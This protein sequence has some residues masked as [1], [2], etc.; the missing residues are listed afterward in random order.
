MKGRLL[1]VDDHADFCLALKH[2]L[3]RRGNVVDCACS[4]VEAL[5]AARSWQPNYALVD[6][7][8]PGSS[9]LTLIP[10]LIAAVPGVRIV[11]MSGYASVA[12]AI[13]AMTLGAVHY[14]VKP[15][16]GAAVEAAFQA[17][18]GVEDAAIGERAPGPPAWE[19][20]Q[21]VLSAHCGNLAATARA[22]GL[23]RG[24]LRR[25]LARRAALH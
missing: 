16:T 17:D 5:H 21:S 10:L 13:E 1:I 20:V 2:A 6:L 12:T 18:G 9:G 4:A 11:L 23:Q 7:C 19:Q 15:V 14:L 8:M 3:E 22:L 25:L 24:T